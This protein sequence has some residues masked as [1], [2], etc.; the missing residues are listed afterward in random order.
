MSLIKKLLGE[1][2]LYGLSSIVGRFMNYLLVPLYTR[3]F[4]ASEYGVV[5]ELYAYAG[6]LM[7]VLSYRME[8]AFFRFG[9]PEAD[10]KSAYATATISLIISTLAIVLGLWIFAQPLADALNYPKHP[11]Y[12]RWFALI[13]GLDC[14]VELP[15]A[16]LRLENRPKR[17]VAIKLTN[18]GLNI[19]LNLFWV[20]FCPWAD[21][22]GHTWVR[23]F[24]SP[25]VGVGY[26]FLA[27]V[28]A[29]GVTLL[30]LLQQFRHLGGHFNVQM[31]RRMMRY[32]GPLIIV[33]MAGIVNEM[34]DRA[35]LTRLL[36]GTLE[37][38]RAQLGIYGANYKLAML[39]TLITQ[40]YRYAAEPFF[41]KSAQQSDGLRLHADATKWFT[42]AST[43]AMLGIL[44]FLDVV[45]GFIG[46]RF[47]S[48]LPVVPILLM[49]NLLLG[50]YYNFS[51]WY[52]LKDRTMTGA[53]ISI[54]GAGIT[55]LLNIWWVPRIGYMG[56]AWATLAC[57]TYM[58][59]ATW[60]MGRQ[61]HP[62]PYPLLRMASYIAFAWGLYGISWVVGWRWPALGAT[63]PFLFWALKCALFLVYVLTVW[64]LERSPKSST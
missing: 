64:K 5:N 47:H 33:G 9:T 11:E 63:A 43:G 39:I 53:W 51:V 23:A 52:R 35:L 27:N 8:S 24:W 7:V 44:L 49:A 56:A 46:A 13:L 21:A 16:R 15:F 48:G 36:T 1:T 2:A 18:I 10:R 58:S 60:W 57:Y 26:V 50:L 45:K 40:A 22:H 4:T 59:L 19:A 6:F 30:L 32:A 61:V 38:N 12:V 34:L 31:W 17:F 3:Q 20:V 37:Q 29:S 42:V 54:V 25:S 28:V 14:L 41:F 55:V 62:V